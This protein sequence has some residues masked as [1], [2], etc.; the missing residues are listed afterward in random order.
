MLQALKNANWH[1]HQIHHSLNGKT[2][3]ELWFTRSEQNSFLI[4]SWCHNVNRLSS[5]APSGIHQLYMT[6]LHY[7]N[8][9]AALSTHLLLIS[10]LGLTNIQHR[11]MYFWQEIIPLR[12]IVFILSVFLLKCVFFR[13]IISEI[14][15]K[16]SLPTAMSPVW[17]QLWFH[18]LFSFCQLPTDF[19]DLL[20]FWHYSK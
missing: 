4:K 17:V 3:N 5:K 12:G 13:E 8:N 20:L 16:M 15:Q 9:P 19:E 10:P 7:L 11:K 18:L 2:K 14:C 6:V 1:L